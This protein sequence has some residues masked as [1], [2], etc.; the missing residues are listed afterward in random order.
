MFGTGRNKTVAIALLNGEGA[1]IEAEG[2][3]IKKAYSF[4]MPVEPLRPDALKAALIKAM[5]EAGV[6]TGK[7]SLSLPDS[8][9]RAAILDFE[10]LPSDAKEVYGVIKW[11]AAKSLYLKP[12]ELRLSYQI[13]PGKEVKAL[14]VVMKEEIIKGIEDALAES[15]I[16]V[17]SISVNS[18]NILNA[19]SNV[20]KGDGIASVVMYFHDHMAV[21]FLKDGV[22]DFYRCKPVESAEE[23]LSEFASSFAFYRGKNPDMALE[24]IYLLSEDAAFKDVLEKNSGRVETLKVNGAEI[25]G[26]KNTLVLSALGAVS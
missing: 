26:V 1:L 13:L 8:S 14:A 4:G 11:K 15:G 6:R 17:E 22:P 5:E 18:L 12:E 23:G 16:E 10:E 20:I 2:T 21:F 19:A 3:H 9:V 24:N 7:V 25:K